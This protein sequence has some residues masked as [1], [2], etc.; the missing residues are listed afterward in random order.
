MGIFLLLFWFFAGALVGC[1]T[2]F[3][4]EQL[5]TQPLSAVLAVAAV[6]AVAAVVC[7]SVCVSHAAETATGAGGAAGAG[8]AAATAS[9]TAVGT[10][11]IAAADV[12]LLTTLTGCT[13]VSAVRQRRCGAVATRRR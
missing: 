8:D 9:G 4:H 7:I 6:A 1:I 11:P 10:T 13:R 3:Q 12:A 5:Q 2:T